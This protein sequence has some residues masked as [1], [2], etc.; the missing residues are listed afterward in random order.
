[1]AVNGS[2][3]GLGFVFSAQDNASRTIEGVG[4]A[5]GRADSAAT[6]FDHGVQ[7]LRRG[8][9]ISTGLLATGVAGLGFAM[10]AAMTSGAEFQHALAGVETL[11]PPNERNTEALRASVE[12]LS[13]TYGGSNA[14]QARALY[15]TISAGI[16]DVADAQQV[17]DVAN[18]L[19]IGG[20]S[21]SETVIRGLAA[22]MNSYGMSASQAEM[23]SDQ[24]FA[25]TAFGMTEID[26]L[27]NQIGR[28]GATAS[29]TGISTTELLGSIGALTQGGLDTGR[30]VSGMGS[31]I[32]NIL[33]PTRDAI[34]EAE[35]LG[36]QF[37]GAALRSMGLRDF[38]G[39]ITSSS[40]FTADSMTR[41]FSSQ[42]GYNAMVKLTSGNL[43]VFDRALQA[44]GGSSGATQQA[45]ERMSETFSFQLTKF[46]GAFDTFRNQVGDAM[47][48]FLAPL[49]S[50][51]NTLLESFASLSPEMK[52]LVSKGIL[53]TFVILTLAG[54]IGLAT[55]GFLLF[56]PAIKAVAISVLVTT[57]AFAIL[58]AALLAGAAVIGTAVALIRYDVGGL[59]TAFFRVIDRIKLA[60]RALVQLFTTGSFSGEVFTEMQRAENGG[61]RAF[62][63]QIYQI[64]FRVKRFFEGIKTGFESTL[65]FM[66]PA[67]DAFKRSISELAERFGFVG[68]MMTSLSGTP[69]QQFAERGARIGAIL[70][71][72]ATFV[73]DLAT[74]IVNFTK[75]MIDGARHTWTVLSPIWESLRASLDVLKDSIMGMLESFGI[76]TE[77][78]RGSTNT[79]T[80][81]G[82]MFGNFLV[83]SVGAFAVVLTAVIDVIN[84]VI[85]LFNLLTRIVQG[86]VTVF[87]SA[88]SAIGSFF[89]GIATFLQDIIDRWLMFIAEIARFVPESM[90]GPGLN[91]IIRAGTNAGDRV[92][93]RIEDATRQAAIGN[94]EM[95]NREWFSPSGETPGTVAANQQS[96]M[97][98][99]TNAA[100]AGV[101]EQMRIQ[102]EQPQAPFNVTMQVD[103]EVLGRV[104]TRG[105]MSSQDA[106]FEPTMSMEPG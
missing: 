12:R 66:Q 41:L 75:G 99:R 24:M 51:L 76:A 16:T 64:G 20:M 36:I 1:V 23:L 79:W 61:V 72:V 85:F 74:S 95:T 33:H 59:G 96:D 56:L 94:F 13:A 89:S 93:T 91:A 65:S 70:G 52:Q 32:A 48:D 27:A 28:L 104:S 21:D 86:I 69:S 4:R 77:E 54:V 26:E 14:D 58:F 97:Q 46:S 80:M 42:E 22:V 71:R 92:N 15:Q 68:D 25:T 40:N 31:A 60:W 8:A 73:V 106:S 83:S 103:G 90:R 50:G 63:I 100:L 49:L 39:Q 81:L 34:Q 87:L 19:A 88:G 98:A 11:I 35:R 82:D 7:A 5:F 2:S 62:A 55:F 102:S 47:M 37:D 29:A 44:V 57:G 18:R 38:L 105:R 101:R 6:A 10:H 78:G 3:L 53:L 30:S 67:I 45:F 84:T 9:A 17:L 43:E